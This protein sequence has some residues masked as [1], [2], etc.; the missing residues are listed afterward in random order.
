MSIIGYQT[1]SLKIKDDNIDEAIT[2]IEAGFEL[3]AE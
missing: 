3:A 2:L 1:S